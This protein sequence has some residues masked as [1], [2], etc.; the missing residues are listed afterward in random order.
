MQIRSKYTYSCWHMCNQQLQPSNYT[1]SEKRRKPELSI[2]QVK[3]LNFYFILGNENVQNRISNYQKYTITANQKSRSSK[4]TRKSSIKVELT[5]YNNLKTN[6]S[7]PRMKKV[8][9]VQTQIKSITKPSCHVIQKLKRRK[10]KSPKKKKI[11]MVELVSVN[12][13][14]QSLGSPHN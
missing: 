8:A 7:E 4:Q 2:N 13:K 1:K 5:A 6:R 10:I 14:L 12:S 11:S 9:T 3:G